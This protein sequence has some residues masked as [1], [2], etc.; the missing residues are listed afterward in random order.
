[1]VV[2]STK[3]IDEVLKKMEQ[4]RHSVHDLLYHL[5]FCPKFR[6][7]IFS[8]ESKGR[9]RSILSYY[10]RLAGARVI[11]SA[12][13]Q[14]HVHIVLR[15]PPQFSIT[16]VICLIKTRSS[17]QFRKEPLLTD[18]F[19]PHGPAWQRGFCIVS[20]GGNKSIVDAYVDRQK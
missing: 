1:M 8:D 20:V 16:S 6:T 10:A 4:N 9:V 5:V 18:L 2:F 19:P 12:V 13:L 14:D 15:I 3:I 11:T 17:K 7:P